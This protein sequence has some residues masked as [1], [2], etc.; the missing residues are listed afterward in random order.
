MCASVPDISIILPAYNHAQ[1]VLEAVE[2][3]RHQT[4]QAWELIVIDDASCDATWAVLQAWQKQHADARVQLLRHTTNQGAP[5]SLNEG[6]SLARGRYLTIL[7]SDDAWHSERLAS[8]YQLAEQHQLDFLA[9]E[10]QL[11]NAASQPEQG[12]TH[13]LSWYQNLRQLSLT[14]ND[15]LAALLAGNF[16]IT[17]SNFFLHRRVYERLGGFT[18]LRYMHD[19]DYVLRL[20]RAGFK[21]RCVWD[22]PLLNYRLHNSNTIRE[23]PLAAIEEN[24]QLLLGQLS[25]EPALNLAQLTQLQSQL[26]D[27][28]RYTREEWLTEIHQWLVAKEAELFPLIQDRDNWIAERDELIAQ[29]QTWITDREVWIAERDV[30]INQQQQWVADRD[31]WIAER[32]QLIN[33]LRAEQNTVYASRSYRLGESLLKPLRWLRE[34]LAEDRVRHA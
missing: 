11:W 22:K 33:Q 25:L 10:V 32:D 9:S 12:E 34:Q 16:L 3:V 14:S 29:Q 8:F 17:T 18:E 5:A 15:A 1:W 28:Y 24:M 23:K 21:W 31:A 4:F 13:W 30:L 7:N 2:S 27:L 20:V 26:R 19:Y 6:L